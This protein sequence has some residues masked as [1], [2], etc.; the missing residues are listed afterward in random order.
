MATKETQKDEEVVIA[1]S[2]TK[3]DLV[4]GFNKGKNY[5]QLAQEF[6]GSEDD[7]AVAKVR[8]VIEKEFPEV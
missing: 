5:Y 4:D 2:V 3:K 7:D 1:K 8:A 6:F